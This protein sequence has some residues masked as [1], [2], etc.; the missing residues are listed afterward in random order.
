[1]TQVVTHISTLA[2]TEDKLGCPSMAISSPL[3]NRL[4]GTCVT[5]EVSWMGTHPQSILLMLTHAYSCLLMLTHGYS[6]FLQ[7]KKHDDMGR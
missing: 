2:K 6:R 3:S 7:G 1:M 4:Y 5:E